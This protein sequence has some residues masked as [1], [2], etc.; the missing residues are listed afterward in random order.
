MVVPSTL[1]ASLRPTP[2]CRR[3]A[4][5]VVIGFTFAGLGSVACQAQSAELPEITVYANQEPTDVSKVGVATTVLRGEDLR[6]RGYRNVSDALRAV[7]GVE[8]SQTGSEG[9]LTHAGIRGS[10][11]KHVLVL[12][13][14]V[15][16]NNLSDGSFD[17]ADFSL[18]G[19]ERIEVIRGPQSGVHGADANAGVIAITTITGRGRKPGG[20][21]RVEGGTQDTGRIAG[22][23]HGSVGAV[24]GAAAFDRTTSAGYNVS[25]FGNDTNGSYRTNVNAT[26]GADV[27]PDFNIEGSVRHVSRSTYVDIQPVD[28]PFAGFAVPSTLLSPPA[29][30]TENFNAFQS[31][32]GRVNARWATFDGAFVQ[33]FGAARYDD[34]VKAFDVQGGAFA[35]DGG[36]DFLN[37]KGT[38]YIP[39]SF[40][41]EK[42]TAT[43]AADWKR[44]TMNLTSDSLSFDP[45]AQAFWAGHPSRNRTGVAG[46]YTIDLPT[47]TTLTGA[48]RRETN[49]GF[50]D[51][52]TW[53]ATASQRL[54]AATRLHA[55][56]GTGVTDPSFIDQFGFFRGSFIGN[57]SLKPESSIGWDAGWEQGWIDGRLVTDLTYFNAQFTDKIV[58]VFDPTFHSTVVNATG[59]SPRQGLEATLKI[60]PVPWAT[61]AASYTYTEAHLPDGTAEVRQ[62]RN[63]AALNITTRW[64]DNRLHVN[65][66]LVFNGAMPDDF[67]GATSSV[68]TLPAYTV[69]D[70]SI[71][72]DIRPDAQVYVRMQN[73]LDRTY[74]EVFSFRAPPF[75][76][77]AGLTM[78]L[79]D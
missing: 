14:G 31:T 11:A 38:V 55:S 6:S 27:T 9:S 67:F 28:G 74:E 62:P 43:F 68:V 12:I 57:P 19:V 21:I 24:Y 77:F 65:G 23:L 4:L 40:F 16:V 2:R 72:Y 13:D 58:T 7:P 22:S 48:V 71:A 30:F 35:T 41:G 61:I 49:S 60:N 46:E 69:V 51:D 17:F 50:A 33:N 45:V 20:D 26:L 56:V 18:E 42:Q 76:A 78:R 39:H 32:Q 54:S 44:E 63:A 8:V 5:V 64:L 34:H 37:Y 52:V 70:A 1:V 36:R 73:V 53:R 15:A 66:G 10:Q 29:P 3:T 47:G 75:A 79:G 25:R 59:V